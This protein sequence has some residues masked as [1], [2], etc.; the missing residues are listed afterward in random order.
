MQ[1]EPH[2]G[3]T[4]AGWR[5]HEAASGA[6]QSG[7][8]TLRDQL[9]K[10]TSTPGLG[11]QPGDLRRAVAEAQA[12]GVAVRALQVGGKTSAAGWREARAASP[13][14]LL[15]ALMSLLAA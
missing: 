1:G 14:A 15:P 8:D 7:V 12:R 6:G 3:R 11:T 13:Q 5:G 10:V 9:A 2:P 4:V